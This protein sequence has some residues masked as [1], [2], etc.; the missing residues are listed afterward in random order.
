MLGESRFSEGNGVARTTPAGVAV[1]GGGA[2]PTAHGVRG[3]AGHVG[4]GDDQQAQPPPPPPI[5]FYKKRWFIV[6]QIIVIPLG[7][8]MLFILLFPVV[9][10]I[11]QLV[12]KHSTL[13][14]DV[15]A[16]TEPQNNT[17]V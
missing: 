8:A 11:V 3:N 2:A 1:G 9:R 10:A 14:V 13:N 16:I 6:S 12:V 4:Y 15:A 7:I 5:S 17:C